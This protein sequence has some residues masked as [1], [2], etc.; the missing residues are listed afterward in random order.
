[1][2]EKW[3]NCCD[4]GEQAVLWPHDREFKRLIDNGFYEGQIAERNTLGE[5]YA[6]ATIL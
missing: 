5:F 3:L 6:R 2:R 1:M 4:K